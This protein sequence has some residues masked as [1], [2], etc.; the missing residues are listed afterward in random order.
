MHSQ[1]LK[2]MRDAVRLRQYIM[3]LH[4]AEEMEDDGFSA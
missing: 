2:K 4:A 1:T 3:T